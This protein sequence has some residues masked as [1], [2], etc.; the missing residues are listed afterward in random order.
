M[1]PYKLADLPYSVILL[2]Q[3]ND[4]IIRTIYAALRVQRP[5]IVTVPV[6]LVISKYGKAFVVLRKQYVS[7]VLE[8]HY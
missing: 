4:A 7:M 6:L 5:A 3:C 2:V 1:E 8:V